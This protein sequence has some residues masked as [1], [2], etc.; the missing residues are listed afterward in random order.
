MKFKKGFS[1]IIS[2]ILVISMFA[3]LTSCS[4]AP[5]D[6][7]VEYTDPNNGVSFTYNSGYILSTDNEEV[8][9]EIKSFSEDFYN[10]VIEDKDTCIAVYPDTQYYIIKDKKNKIDFTSS[11]FYYLDAGK[12]FA[13]IKQSDIDDYQYQ[14][15]TTNL[16]QQAELD[17]SVAT[18]DTTNKFLTFGENEYLH[19]KINT[20]ADDGDMVYEQFLLQLDN[21][22]VICFILNCHAS[23]YDNA[24][25]N[26]TK[27]LESVHIPQVVNIN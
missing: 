8:V 18:A 12:I 2:I 4:K 19:T 13:D 16:E 26:V 17:G 7:F 25:K 14:A 20:T 1:S 5:A 11:T 22:D 21:N 23:E 15:L 24:Y 10:E 9:T 27:V 6:N 3:I